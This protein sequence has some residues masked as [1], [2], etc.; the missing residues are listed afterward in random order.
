MK[1][2]TI[3]LTDKQYF[4]LKERALEIQKQNQNA[5]IVSLIR[6]L[7]DR[8]RDEWEKKKSSLR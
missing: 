2:T 8:D 6:A 4:Y 5:S 7:I 3:E 1:K